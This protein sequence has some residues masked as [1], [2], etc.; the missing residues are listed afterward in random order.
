MYSGHVVLGV[1]HGPEA[2]E[3]GPFSIWI[4]FLRQKLILFRKNLPFT[5]VLYN[6]CVK[7]KTILVLVKETRERQYSLPFNAV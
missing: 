1:G 7:D 6:R 5:P 3:E 2:F 4:Y